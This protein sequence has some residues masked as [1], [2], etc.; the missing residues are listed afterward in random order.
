MEHVEK[1]VSQCCVMDWTVAGF[2]EDGEDG[3]SCTFLT[4]LC[5]LHCKASKGGQLSSLPPKGTPHLPDGQVH[6]SMA[7]ETWQLGARQA[8]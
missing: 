4:A 7:S 1:F 5:V 6:N 2:L 3:C 8:G